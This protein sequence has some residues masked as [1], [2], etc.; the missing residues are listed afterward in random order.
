MPVDELPMYPTPQQAAYVV[1]SP[2]SQ[3]KGSHPKANVAYR[4]PKQYQVPTQG[5]QSAPQHHHQQAPPPQQQYY[6]PQQT[7]Q[8]PVQH[9]NPSP[10]Q[11]QYAPTPQQYYQ[12]HQSPQSSVFDKVDSNGSGKISAKELSVALLNF[13]NTRFQ[14]STVLLMI[15]LFSSSS[16]VASAPLKSLNFDQ[17]VSLWKYLSAYK[18]LFVQADT[19]KS[20]D[21]SFGE[22]QKILEQI[23]YKLNIDLVLN[24][25]QKFCYKDYAG[26]ESGSVGKLKFDAFI[27]LLVYL[28][29]LTDV[30]KKYDKDLSGVATISFADFLFEVS[31]LS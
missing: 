4:P 11:P 16:D 6:Q 18:K 24:L 12:G 8:P 2:P 1:G 25:F 22:F 14:E 20:G 30:F 28:R 5:Y 29:K 3:R 26:H 10:A 27:E 31:N 9:Y 23:G 17:F 7:P 13:D 19:N 21:I 15:R